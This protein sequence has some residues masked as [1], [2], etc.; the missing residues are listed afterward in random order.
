MNTPDRPSVHDKAMEL[1]R[2]SEAWVRQLFENLPDF[3]V[4]VDRN[5]TIRFANHGVGEASI[6]QLIGSPAMGFIAP[7]Y[8]ETC[9]SLLA[10][11]LET[12]QVQAIEVMEVFDL[13]WAARIVPAGGRTEVAM[14]ICT[15]VTEAHNAAQRLR[16]E[17]EL[18]Q[19]LLEFHERDRRRAAYHL[20]DDIAQPLTGA[21]L[22]LQGVREMH[23][24]DPQ[25][26]WGV[27][28]TAMALLGEV[29]GDTRRI[30]SELRPPILDEAGIISATEYLVQEHLQDSAPEIEFVHDVQFERLSPLL[31]GH[32]FRIVQEL[33]VNALRHSHSE[34][35]RVEIVQRDGVLSVSV[36]DWGRGFDCGA[37]SEGRF[38]LQRTRE[39]ARLLGGCVTIETA[40]N[41]GTHVVVELP[42]EDTAC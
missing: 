13:W 38:G 41:Q 42:L 14:I 16:K 11:A 26:A 2:G 31:E 12:G 29:I 27:F 28:S 6:E 7:P 23:L 19:Q 40:P 22:H 17:Q 36:R 4:L 15:D 8:R 25:Q 34:K 1:L 24:R 9:L 20:H 3:I 5:A 10:R 21:L 30:I 39:R 32:V 33:L 35:V 18:L 37:T